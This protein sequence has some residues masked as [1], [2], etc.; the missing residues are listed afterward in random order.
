[1]C[2]RSAAATFLLLPSGPSRSAHSVSFKDPLPSQKS[3]KRVVSD[4]KKAFL[5]F[6]QFTRAGPSF[7]FEDAA[8]C[9]LDLDVSE[10]V[11]GL[12]RDPEITHQTPAILL[13]ETYT[14]HCGIY[15]PCSQESH[16]CCCFLSL[17]VS[18][19][20]MSVRLVSLPAF[21]RLLNTA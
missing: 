17:H 8:L 4:C 19:G 20:T 12:L 21:K 15:L 16:Y 14:P 11:I 10:T 9:G 1:M 18:F 13:T 5:C 2:L 3:L 6:K 7:P